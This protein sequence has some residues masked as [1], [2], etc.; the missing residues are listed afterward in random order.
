MKK[1]TFMAALSAARE[2]WLGKCGFLGGAPPIKFEQLAE[3][4]ANAGFSRVLIAKRSKI[5]ERIPRERNRGS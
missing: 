1:K 2:V 3:V 5:R 4:V